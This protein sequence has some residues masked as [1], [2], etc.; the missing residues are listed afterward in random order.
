VR[1]C[2]TRGQLLHLVNNCAALG[3]GMETL[4]SVA[5]WKE[6]IAAPDVSHGVACVVWAE[7]MRDA[8]RAG[9]WYDAL[10]LTLTTRLHVGSPGI[11]MT[12]QLISP[13]KHQNLVL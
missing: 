7:I 8:S 10:P 13:P 6:N 1:H 3:S 4:D 12:T 2:E 11:D 5:I 9:G